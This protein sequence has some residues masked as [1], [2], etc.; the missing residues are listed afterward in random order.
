MAR[1]SH[2][3]FGAAVLSVL[4]FSLIS[5]AAELAPDTLRAWNEYIQAENAKVA[6]RSPGEPFLWI[7]ESPDRR[8]RVHDGEILI[9]PAAKNVPQGVPHGLI[10]H[11]IGAAFLPDTR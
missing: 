9:A 2:K 10:H 5:S 7:D 8:R 6:G 11:W 1:P 4:G 3:L